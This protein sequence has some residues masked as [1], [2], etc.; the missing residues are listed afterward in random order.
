MTKHKAQK[1]SAQPTASA[2]AA[3]AP[4][5]TQTG[6]VKP[7]SARRNQRPM[8][9]SMVLIVAAI[10]AVAIWMF[11]S[12][13][14]SGAVQA[15]HQLIS[16]KQYQTEFATTKQSHMLIDVRTPEEF[17]SGHIAGAVNIS[18][19]TLPQR[20]S[21]LPK[22]QPLVLYCRSGSRSN[23]AAQMLARAGF[24]NIY[25]LGGVIDWRAAGLPLQ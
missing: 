1:K 18:L 21:T 12:Q 25:D 10:A 23:S 6:A 16:P 20:I 8:T 3:V 15:T 13:A 24:T 22:D 19:Q 4:T 17:A 14:R 9:L 11:L 7:N 5:K 2:P